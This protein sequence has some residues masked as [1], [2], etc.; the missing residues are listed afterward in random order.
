M[1]QRSNRVQLTAQHQ[2]WKLAQSLNCSHPSHG[3]PVSFHWTVFHKGLAKRAGTGF[4]RVKQPHQP[5]A[6]GTPEQ[7]SWPHSIHHVVF[8]QNSFFF[9]SSCICGQHRARRCIESSVQRQNKRHSVM[10]V[11]LKVAL[12]AWL[13]GPGTICFRW[14]TDAADIKLRRAY[15]YLMRVGP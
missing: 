13:S 1:S 14:K 10:G 11:M 9:A 12:F 15:S 2:N 7:P 4:N 3:S 6:N 5:P 8:R